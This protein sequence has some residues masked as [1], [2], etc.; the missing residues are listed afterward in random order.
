MILPQQQLSSCRTSFWQIPP[1]IKL[2]PFWEAAF[3]MLTARACRT[4]QTG[5]SHSVNTHPS[6]HQSYPPPFTAYTIPTL[7]P[8]LGLSLASTRRYTASTVAI[9]SH[10]SAH[11]D[12]HLPSSL[13][14][15][16]M[17]TAALYS[18]SS[19]PALVQSLVGV[20]LFW[21]ISRPAESHQSFP[22]ILSIP[23]AT[24]APSRQANSSS[25]RLQS[26]CSS[27]SPA[28]S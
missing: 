12:F 3:K 4:Y 6:P 21:T 17:P 11:W 22:D 16:S 13:H 25:C 26:S 28:C 27:G 24:I 19:P 20:V 8:P 10:L 18:P 9:S 7:P 1:P 5:L 2:F 14:S 23:G 15:T